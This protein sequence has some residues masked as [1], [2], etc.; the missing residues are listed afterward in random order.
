[1]RNQSI[2]WK[3]MLEIVHVSIIGIFK[4]IHRFGFVYYRGYC[5]PEFCSSH[6]KG[7]LSQV[8]FGAGKFQRHMNILESHSRHIIVC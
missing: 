3:V 2:V 4:D 5:V 7:V 6:G 8:K 1:M